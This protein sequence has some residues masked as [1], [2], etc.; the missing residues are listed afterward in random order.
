MIVLHKSDHVSDRYA[1]I[2]L[3]TLSIFYRC[4]LIYS[5]IIIYMYIH[6]YTPKLTATASVAQSVER[7]SRDPVLWV[8]FPGGGLGVAFFPVGS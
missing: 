7:W 3:D 2:T 4:N 1:N 6:I 8:Q 5:Y